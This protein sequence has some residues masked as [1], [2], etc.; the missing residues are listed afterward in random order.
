MDFS[1]DFWI[2]CII[3]HWQFLWNFGQGSAFWLLFQW[4]YSSVTVIFSLA[5]AQALVLIQPKC[6][7]LNKPPPLCILIWTFLNKS[8][9]KKK[10]KHLELGSF[11]CGTRGRRH[12]EKRG[13]EGVQ[14]VVVLWHSCA[15]IDFINWLSGFWS[16][17]LQNFLSPLTTQRFRQLLFCAHWSCLHVDSCRRVL[18]TFFITTRRKRSQGG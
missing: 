16:L 13:G 17:L 4:T 9:L 11:K 18:L 2:F 12:A 10:W 5:L 1:V 6:P 7:F 3:H 8:F 14:G 15:Q